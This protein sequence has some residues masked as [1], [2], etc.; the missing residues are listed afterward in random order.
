MGTTNWFSNL[1]KSEEAR[2]AELQ[3]EEDKQAALVEELA[4]KRFKDF[5]NSQDFQDMLRATA[6]Q[7]VEKTKQQKIDEENRKKKEY[8]AKME[9]AERDL[10]TLNE[11]MQDSNEPWV[12]IVSSS[13]DP[14][15]GIKIKLDWN[16]AFIHYLTQ[17]GV[18]GDSEDE[19]VRIWLAFL[20][21]DIDRMA[22][23]Q[24]YLHSNEAPTD[25]F[26]GNIDDLIFGQDEYGEDKKDDFDRWE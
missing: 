11:K 7:V 12:H 5:K 9:K 6:E 23:A 2:K 16:Q 24:D 10:E 8:T 22:L 4:A 18:K 17:Q 15:N 21:Q 3:A 13:F 19:I 14:N 25:K 20:S 26:D 1:F